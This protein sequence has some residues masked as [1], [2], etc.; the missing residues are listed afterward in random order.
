MKDHMFW[1][2]FLQ[3][4]SPEAYLLFSEARKVKDEYVS[5]HTRP[6]DQGNQIQ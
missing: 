2:M 5:D 3:T 4:G 6:G 1:N